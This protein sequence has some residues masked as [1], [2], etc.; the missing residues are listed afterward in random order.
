MF[1]GQVIGVFEA[2]KVTEEKIVATIVGVERRRPEA[3]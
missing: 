2:A 1:L 3:V